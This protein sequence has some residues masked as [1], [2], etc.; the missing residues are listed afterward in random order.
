M[1]RLSYIAPLACLMLVV[2]A[3]AQF[4]K[5]GDAVEYR[6][7]VF[8]VMSHHFGLI[9]RALK[10]DIPF[11]TEE[12]SANANLV[13]RLA[14]LPWGAFPVGSTTSDSH[15]KPEIWKKADAFKEL[16]ERLQTQTDKLAA[17]AKDGDASAVK[18]AFGDVAKTCKE[19]HDAFRTKHE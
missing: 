5:S 8:T 3:Y 15:A 18:A 1:K 11:K 10:G 19:C 12:V 17:V 6:Q 7:G 16:A 2:P 14:K 9:S 13:A 4:T